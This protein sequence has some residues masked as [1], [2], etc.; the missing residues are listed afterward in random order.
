[1]K[2]GNTALIGLAAF[3]FYFI[4]SLLV[5]Y[6]SRIREYFADRSSVLLGNKPA[7][8]GSGLYKLVYV[9]SGWRENL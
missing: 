3:I 5:L 6:D 9:Q 4:T 8:L 1:M 2:Q 7:W